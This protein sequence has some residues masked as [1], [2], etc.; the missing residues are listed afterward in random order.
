MIAVGMPPA[1]G[2]VTQ[3]FLTSHSGAG[4]YVEWAVCANTQNESGDAVEHEACST[5][6]QVV[7]L[8]IEVVKYGGQVQLMCIGDELR[9]CVEVRRYAGYRLVTVVTKKGGI[10][11]SLL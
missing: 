9:R 5:S 10:Q 6:I 3:C 2:V 1:V 11:G 4:M 8:G 7:Y